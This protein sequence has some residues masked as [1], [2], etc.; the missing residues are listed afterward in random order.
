V[1]PRGQKTTG[2]LYRLY[3]GGSGPGSD[4]NGLLVPLPNLQG[5]FTRSGYAGLFYRSF[6]FARSDTLANLP[7][8]F[9]R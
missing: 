6:F 7:Y 9:A 3:A 2:R 5:L 4:T 8:W 1:Y